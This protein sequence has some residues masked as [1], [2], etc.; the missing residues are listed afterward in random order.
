MVNIGFHYDLIFWK[1]QT[2]G[3]KLLNVTVEN[4]V[5]EDASVI[6]LNLRPIGTDNMADQVC[7]WFFNNYY[8]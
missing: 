5:W 8:K 2:H 7:T 1:P 6:K 3:M 4:N